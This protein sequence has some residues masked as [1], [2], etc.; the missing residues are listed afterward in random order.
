MP[1]AR[2]MH[3]LLSRGKDV[4]SNAR[5]AARAL[6]KVRVHDSS[7]PSGTLVICACGW[8]FACMWVTGGGGGIAWL[9]LL[10]LFVCLARVCVKNEEGLVMT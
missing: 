2:G 4:I 5:K 1:R 7:R 8:M 9:R 3:S 6:A 10:E